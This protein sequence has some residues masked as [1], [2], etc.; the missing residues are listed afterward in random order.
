MPYRELS[1]RRNGN[2]D[3]LVKHISQMVDLH[4]SVGVNTDVRQA[5]ML[6]MYGQLQSLVYVN[7]NIFYMHVYVSHNGCW[8]IV[9][10][11]VSVLTCYKRFQSITIFTFLF[12]MTFWPIAMLL[13]LEKSLMSMKHWQA[14]ILKICIAVVEAYL[15]MHAEEYGKH[16]G[17]SLT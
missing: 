10:R 5:W 12:P 6:M 7:W 2:I 9:L 15:I 16:F 1:L 14:I 17:L 11:H 4:C 8:G 13:I 3:V